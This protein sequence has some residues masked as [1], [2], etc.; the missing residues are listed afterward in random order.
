MPRN[1]P[2]KCLMLLLPSI[3]FCPV[4]E[5][6]GGSLLNLSGHVSVYVDVASKA[7][8][9]EEGC[10]KLRSLLRQ[11][12]NHLLEPVPTFRIIS[13]K[14]SYLSSRAKI[15][16]KSTVIHHCPKRPMP[17]QN[18]PLI[19]SCPPAPCPHRYSFSPL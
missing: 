2:R 18:L 16:L 15:D 7:G 9:H 5:R 4:V 1:M 19:P 6:D 14:Q 8:S 10:R 12:Q 3:S 17:E 13:T 11:T